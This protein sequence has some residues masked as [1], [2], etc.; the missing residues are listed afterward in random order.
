MAVS[1]GQVNTQRQEQGQGLVV[2]V[3]LGWVGLELAF[4]SCVGLELALALV[5]QCQ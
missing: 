5:Q 4:Y 1:Y 3:G 2:V